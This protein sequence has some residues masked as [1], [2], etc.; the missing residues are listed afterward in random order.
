[1]RTPTALPTPNQ[2]SKEIIPPRELSGNDRIRLATLRQEI[3]RQGDSLM[4]S[5]EATWIAEKQM[6]LI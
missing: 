1:M 4:T 5:L 6:R 3:Q 2:I